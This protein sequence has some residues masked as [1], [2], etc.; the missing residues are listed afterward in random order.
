M[1]QKLDI[2][3]IYIAGPMTGL[4]EFNYPAF[5]AAEKMLN[6]I[7]F[8]AVSPARL[9]EG[10]LGLPWTT[11]MRA[12]VKALCDCQLVYA[13][14]GHETSRGAQVEL[15]LA[16]TLGIPIIYQPAADGSFIPA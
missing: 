13:L 14:C 4:P 8:H 15:A 16:S 2:L 9:F 6:G 1:T 12:G 10:Q 11:Y 5:H 7:G 3:S